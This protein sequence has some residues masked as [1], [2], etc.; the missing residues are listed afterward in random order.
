MES[1]VGFHIWIFEIHLEC[2]WQRH[3]A[4]NKA[5]GVSFSIAVQQRREGYVYKGKEEE[6]GFAGWKEVSNSR[7]NQEL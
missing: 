4:F 6:K 1:D 7:N 5:V 3:P 2:L